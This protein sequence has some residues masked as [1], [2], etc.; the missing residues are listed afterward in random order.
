M[1]LYFFRLKL[2]WKIQYTENSSTA[3]DLSE[4]LSDTKEAD[5]PVIRVAVIDNGL[6][7]PWKHP[8]V[9]SHSFDLFN[10]I[11]NKRWRSYP[12]GWAVKRY[13]FNQF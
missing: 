2:I 3:N 1:V 11:C 8:D 7:F 4:N 9:H 10:T 13:N 6:A 12:F 5:I